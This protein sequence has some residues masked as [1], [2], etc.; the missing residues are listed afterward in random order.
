MPFLSKKEEQGCLLPLEGER[1]EDLVLLKGIFEGAGDVLILEGV[2][3][4]GEGDLAN[5]GSCQNVVD[6]VL[7][8]V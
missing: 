1:E 7:S 2:G 4:V 6:G 8:A 5:D 3:G